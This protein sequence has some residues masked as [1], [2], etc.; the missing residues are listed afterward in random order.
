M[1]LKVKSSSKKE[2]NNFPE[3][4]LVAI[5]DADYCSYP[6]A[7]VGD[8]VV[9]KVVHTKTGKEKE[10]KNK[11]AFQGR[12]SKT[13]GGWLG[14]ENE[15]REGKGK[16]PFA[17][18]DFTLEVV[19]RR[20]KEFKILRDDD[21]EQTSIEE[22]SDDEALRN[23]FHSAKSVILSGLKALGTDKYEA[24]LGK[25]KSFRLDVSTLKKYKGNRDKTLRPLVM[26]EVSEYIQKAFS[27]EVVT[28]IE[29]DDKVVMRAYGD[30][31]A[32]VVGVD[33]DHYGSPIKFF[34][35]NR[36]EEGIIDGN[37]FGKL[38]VQGTGTKEKI[39]GFGRLF[40]YWQM[41]S[42]DTADNY[43]AN[44]HSDV[45]WGAKSAY[46]LL[47][48]AKDDKEAIEL[49][50]S[51]FKKLYPEPKVVES[52]RGHSMM[53]DWLYVM[54]EMYQLVTMKRWV[55]DSRTI[56]TEM[57]IYEVKYEYN[58][59]TQNNNKTED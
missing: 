16:K 44:C 14:A 9:I 41:C 50:I 34:N 51:C 54:R 26:S 22:L 5:L 10:F 23:I 59:D 24:Y 4:E 42:E 52:W 37:C 27:A 48:E 43:K 3:S 13:I 8:E 38:W 25:G 33:K 56:D 53:I 30:P 20:K 31:N 40:A 57:E 45:K 32:V 6:C 21:G 58:T 18:D 17:L 36:P 7:S 39:R 2:L 49:M 1:G 35:V 12:S 46:K 28:G 55:G 11:T 15:K 29:N 47:C 19:Q